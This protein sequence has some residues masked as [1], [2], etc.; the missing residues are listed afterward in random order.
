M[1]PD[2]CPRGNAGRLTKANLVWTRPC[3]HTAGVTPL[4][5]QLQQM[6]DGLDLPPDR[7][8]LSQV[9]PIFVPSSFFALGNW[10]G[11]FTRLRAPELG[12]TWTVLLPNQSMRYVDF[13]M[14]HHWEA[15]KLDWKEL[16]MRNLNRETN[17]RPGVREMRRPTGRVSALAFLFE[18]GLGPSRLLFRQG[19]EV[20]FPEGYRVAMPE[21]SCGLAFAQ[22]L[23]GEEMAPIQRVIDHCYRN[24]TRPLFPTIFHPD[25]LLPAEPA[26]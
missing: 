8:D 3:G 17:E 4:E 2:G 9:M 13:G 25:D 20:R 16:A 14:V 18:D 11:P 21:R 22:D 19:L 26:A 15:Q 24:G 23:Q 10:P 12:L 5:T 6:R 7:V 1:E